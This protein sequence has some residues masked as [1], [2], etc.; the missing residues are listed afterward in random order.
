MNPCDRENDWFDPRQWD[1]YGAGKGLEYAWSVPLLLREIASVAEE[2]DDR[3]DFVTC[4]PGMERGQWDHGLVD[5]MTLTTGFFAI[6]SEII[7]PTFPPRKYWHASVGVYA[8]NGLPIVQIPMRDSELF[9]LS[10]THRVTR[11]SGLDGV[12]CQHWYY[13]KIFERLK[14]AIRKATGSVPRDAMDQ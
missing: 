13:E 5:P 10:I 2:L 12:F 9:H 6:R 8:V 7:H 1:R 14:K 4:E 11:H 3:L